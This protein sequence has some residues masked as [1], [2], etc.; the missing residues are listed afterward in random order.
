MYPENRQGKAEFVKDILDPIAK[1]A[2]F[3][4]VTYEEDT[5]LYEEAIVIRTWNGDIAYTINV[6]ADSCVA[7]VRDFVK[8]F[9]VYV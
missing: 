6:H 1:Q 4:S 3:A 8:Q 9:L 7:M 2:G 5:D